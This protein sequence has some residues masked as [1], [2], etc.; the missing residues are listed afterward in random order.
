M[1]VNALKKNASSGSP[2]KKKDNAFTPIIKLLLER[3]E[4]PSTNQSKNNREGSKSPCFNPKTKKDNP[5]VSPFK[6]ANENPEK[7]VAVENKS[8]ILA[9]VSRKSTPISI[10]VS[11]EEKNQYGDRSLP[12]YEKLELIGK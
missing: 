5:S 10:F 1:L 12:D 8:E 9:N 11:E 6:K 4:P 2:F 3:T 7:L